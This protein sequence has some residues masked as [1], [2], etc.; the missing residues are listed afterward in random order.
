MSRKISRATERA[1]TRRGGRRPLLIGRSRTRATERA[2]STGSA[3]DGWKI[4]VEGAAVWY[5]YRGDIP[6]FSGGMST[7]SA[8]VSDSKWPRFGPVPLGR[9]PGCGRTASLKRRVTTSDN[10][11]N[12][13]REYVKCESKEQPGE[14]RYVFPPSQFRFMFPQIW[15]SADLGF[16]P[17]WVCIRFGFSYLQA[18][19]HF[20][21]LDLYI[22]RIEKEGKSLVPNLPQA[23]EQLGS[24]TGVVATVQNGVQK[25]ELKKMAKQL[26][27]LVDLKK[28]SNLLAAIFY[29]CA[30]VLGVV[31]LLIISQK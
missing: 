8:S 4:A 22:K 24:A 20:E 15:V 13:G 14:A 3:A 7:S 27:K 5:S 18:C 31:Y 2:A 1:A 19:G 6:F 17:I 10:N 25:D 28:Q 23:V 29:L 12:R 11:G 30:I 21:W 26:E 9:C 16:H